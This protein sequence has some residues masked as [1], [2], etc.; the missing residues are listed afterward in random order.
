MKLFFTTVVSALGSA[1][2]V[3]AQAAMEAPTVM[4]PDQ[5]GAAALPS[6]VVPVVVFTLLVGAAAL[7]SDNG[8]SG[9]SETPI[10]Y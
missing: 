7:S 3:L 9:G 10:P 5:T 2:A 8:G 6:W 4:S 1:S